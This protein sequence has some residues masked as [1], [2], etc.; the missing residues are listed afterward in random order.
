MHKNFSNEG[1]RLNVDIFRPPGE[2]LLGYGMAKDF[3]IYKSRG[4]EVPANQIHN[5]P[6]QLL[7]R[8][9]TVF[10]VKSQIFSTSYQSY[11]TESLHQFQLPI[12][13]IEKDIVDLNPKAL[14]IGQGL[15]YART[16]ASSDFADLY[17]KDLR[18]QL[19]H[20][21]DISKKVA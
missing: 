10:K 3:L 2:G 19:K 5:L 18:K 1:H 21:A 9:D 12:K 13:N 7:M 15:W 4:K 6:K 20:F 16:Y 8:W 14:V 17:R 11:T